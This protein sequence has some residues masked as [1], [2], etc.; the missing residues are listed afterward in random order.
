ME[1]FESLVEAHYQD[2]YRFLLR[3]CGYRTECAEEL[4]QETFY[5]AY[6]SIAGFQG[7]CSLKT[8]L[9]QIARNCFY[10]MLRKRGNFPI[11]A[12]EI[13]QIPSM[14]AENP[15]E[16]AIRS[17]LLLDARTVIDT[18]P[19]NMREV[20]LYR[21]YSDLKYAQIARLLCISE[22]S[23]KVLYHRGKAILRTKLKEDYGY[24]L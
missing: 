9:M 8:W 2:V 3:L 5:Q 22:S 15:E 7:R 4:T 20:L 13:S 14:P 12:G 17:Q 10:Q 21:L 23:A 24:E 18:L 16:A 19:A 6:V 11:A 1:E